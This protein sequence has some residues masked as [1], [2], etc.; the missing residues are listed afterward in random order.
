MEF[1][2]G[3]IG[4]TGALFGSA[5]MG[6]ITGILGSFANGWLK[7]KRFPQEME[8]EK[9][10]F[11]HKLRLME[12]K[13]SQVGMMKSYDSEIALAENVPS[14]A[15]GIKT[16]WRPALTMLLIGLTGFIF[17]F[18]STGELTLETGTPST[19]I[20]TYLVR[21]IVFTT[22]TAILWWFG[23]RAQTITRKTST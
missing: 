11:E 8:L 15:A 1:W 19:E 22:A 2:E 18:L 10:R 12:T 20:M 16:L 3:I 6:G 13:H 7:Q 5:G 9:M 14:W 21:T 23:D 17:Y 4:A